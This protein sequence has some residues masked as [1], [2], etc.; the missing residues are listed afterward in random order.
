MPKRHRIWIL[1]HLLYVLRHVIVLF[2]LWLL[3]V[4]L[5]LVYIT[6]ATCQRPIGPL[7]SINVCMYVLRKLSEYNWQK[8]K[9]V[10]WRNVH[11]RRNLVVANRTCLASHKNRNAIPYFKRFCDFVLA[12]NS[13]LGGPYHVLFPRYWDENSRKCHELK[14]KPVHCKRDRAYR[15]GH[16]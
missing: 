12:A 1:R 15:L 8:A 14:L 7:L 9:N 2:F 16:R 10:C 13:N 3:F 11:G 4:K 6:I 5:L